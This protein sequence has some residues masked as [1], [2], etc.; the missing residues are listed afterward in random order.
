MFIDFASYS[1]ELLVEIQKQLRAEIAERK[2]TRGI[3]KRV[4]FI[5]NL[6]P[7]AFGDESSFNRAVHANNSASFLSLPFQEGKCGTRAKYLKSLLAQDWSYFFRGYDANQSSFYVYVHSDPRENV[8][9]VRPEFGGNYGGLPFYVGKG[10]GQRAWDLKR[11]QGHGKKIREILSDGFEKGDLVKIVFDNLSEAKAM[12]IEAKLIYFFGTIYER[13]RGSSL[14]N[15]DLSCRPEFVGEMQKFAKT[16]GG[17]SQYRKAH[18][19]A[20]VKADV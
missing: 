15:L 14:L 10:Q 5:K 6:N 9:V 13:K 4:E 17:G 11:N 2:R 16:S 20:G 3:K 18:K 19:R 1:D 12:E 7:L 8:F